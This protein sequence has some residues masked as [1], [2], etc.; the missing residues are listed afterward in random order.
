[1]GPTSERDTRAGNQEND[2]QKTMKERRTR[3]IKEESRKEKGSGYKV[4]RG[5]SEGGKNSKG[6]GFQGRCWARDQVGHSQNQCPKGGGKNGENKGGKGIKG[7][8]GVAERPGVF[9]Q[10]A[11]IGGEADPSEALTIY[12]GKG[13]IQDDKYHGAD[14]DEEIWLTNVERGSD[15]RYEYGRVPELDGG[16]GTDEE[17]QDEEKNAEEDEESSDDSDEEGKV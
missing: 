7:I 1:M 2:P 3:N 8:V 6:E 11:S 12:G 4:W 9:K 16:G 17:D 13:R 5:A 10:I 15:P 14:E